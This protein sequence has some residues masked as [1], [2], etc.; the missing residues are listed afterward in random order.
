[1]SS[2]IDGAARLPGAQSR[3]VFVAYPYAIPRADYRRPFQVVGKAFNV[4]FVFADEK[5]SDLHILEKIRG[6]IRDS[7]FG[8]YDI[9]GWNPNVALELGLAFGLGKTA[10]IAFDPSK[11]ASDEVPTDLRGMD[12]L[13]YSSFAEL[14]SRLEWLIG[15][16]LPLPRA[17]DAEN[18][19]VEL[20]TE[21]LALV[22][23]SEGL[24]I[25]DIAKA[26]GI[27]TDLAKVVVRPMIGEGLRT[28][29]ERRGTKYFANE[30]GV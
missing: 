9:T 17:H 6:Y 14:E 25:G 24:R 2:V 3:Q 11:T 7:V 26:V 8:V 19:L 21:V 28:T 30:P 29:G 5:I 18:Q 4:N 23:A 15:Q 12:R 20:R 22:E 10:Y 27:T 16:E 1:M 13:Q